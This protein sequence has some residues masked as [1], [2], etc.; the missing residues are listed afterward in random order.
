MPGDG[1]SSEDTEDLCSLPRRKEIKQF[2]ENLDVAE[3]AAKVI[4]YHHDS[5]KVCAIHLVF[6]VSDN[7]GDSVTKIS[8]CN[9]NQKML[10]RLGTFLMQSGEELE[11]NKPP[12]TF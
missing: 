6:Q 5:G 7:A 1:E 10:K 9:A 4:S 11:K 3:F 12:S 8:L 2:D